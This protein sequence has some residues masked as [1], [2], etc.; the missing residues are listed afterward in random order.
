MGVKVKRYFVLIILLA[1][2]LSMQG[3]VMNE[4]QASFDKTNDGNLTKAEPIH[5]QSMIA[6]HLSSFALTNRGELYAWGD[7]HEGVL[8]IGH[9]NSAETP[10]RVPLA[11]KITQVIPGSFTVALTE[12]GEIYIWGVN[13]F[14]EVLGDSR[15]FDTRPVSFTLP[16]KIVKIG[17]GNGVG[18]AISEKGS[19]YTWGWNYYGQR[20][21]G[22]RSHSFVPY[23]V[24][25][26]EPVVDVSCIHS[27]VMALSETGKVYTWG[28]NFFGEIGDGGPVAY[29]PGGELIETTIPT[30]HKVAFD[31]KI[32]SIATGRCA[33]YALDEDGRLY[34]WGDNAVGQLGIAN[35]EVFNSST[36]LRVAIPQKVTKI[37]SGYFHALALTEDGA[38]YSWGFNSGDGKLSVIGN[39]ST[40]ESFF[41]PQR[42]TVPGENTSISAGNGYTWVITKN[43]GIYGWGANGYGQIDA[44]LSSHINTPTKI[45]LRLE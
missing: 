42:I 6:G 11:K 15:T 32:I 22:G 20:G 35:K 5:V 36:P 16:E 10:V 2:L 4:G 13:D 31:K 18:L 14:P 27:H 19:L 7:N 28:S 24:D 45:S 33:S 1:G 25:L 41:Q 39:G 3:C 8:G 21:D 12:D 40:E 38:L 23:K 30:P 43:D 9:T 34:A 37:D 44:K 29:K 26:P 17:R